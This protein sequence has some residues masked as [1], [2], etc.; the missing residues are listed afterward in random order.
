M[1]KRENNLKDKKTKLKNPLFFISPTR[2]AIK[3]LGE[4]IDANK[5]KKIC[6]RYGLLFPSYS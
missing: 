3:N 4:H 2:L 6:L 5:L 1:V